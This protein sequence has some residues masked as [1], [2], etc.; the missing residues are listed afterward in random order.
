MTRALPGGV[1]LILDNALSQAQVDR[2]LVDSGLVVERTLNIA[3]YAYFIATEPGL[4][5][6]NMAN[7]LEGDN[8]S[9]R[10]VISATLI[11]GRT[12]SDNATLLLC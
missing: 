7:Q 10:Y 11:G 3:R 2:W 9:Q 6:I 8:G 12:P 4:A 5:S 1:V